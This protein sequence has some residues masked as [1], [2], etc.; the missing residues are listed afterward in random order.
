MGMGGSLETLVNAPQALETF[1]ADGWNSTTQWW[2]SS[3]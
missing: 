2:I 3:R 1:T